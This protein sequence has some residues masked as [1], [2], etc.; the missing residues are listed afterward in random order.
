MAD[1]LSQSGFDK[2]IESL[3][4]DLVKAQKS[5]NEKVGESV[6]TSSV[7]LENMMEQTTKSL[8]LATQRSTEMIQQTLISQFMMSR[9]LRA[10]S[11]EE[12]SD[13]LTGLLGVATAAANSAKSFQQDEEA[14]EKKSIFL[15]TNMKNALGALVNLSSVNKLSETERRREEK[16]ASDAMLGAITELGGAFETF[17]GKLK[18][19]LGLATNPLALIGAILGV[20]AG[21][22]AGLFLRAKQLSGLLKLGKLLTKMFAPLKALFGPTTKL[23]KAVR[24]VANLF[25]P[26]TSFFKVI[27]DLIQAFVK[28]SGTFSKIFKFMKPFIKFGSSL[29]GKFFIPITVIISIFKGIFGFIDELK[30]GGDV[31]D[32]SLRAI[33]D[34]LDFLSFGLIDAD[35]L[36]EFLGK[37]LREFI[38]GI[39][40]L[41]TEGFS[42]KTLKKLA[43]SLIKIF[44]S[45]Q[46]IVLKSLGK[47]V[48]FILDKLGF[49]KTAE[50]IRKFFA[51]FNLGE[52][53]ANIFDP[54]I[55]IF[56]FI[57]K[58]IFKVGGFIIKINVAVAKFFFNI[59]KGVAGFI[60]KSITFG[61]KIGQSI[62]DMFMK[63]IKDVTDFVNERFERTFGTG[64]SAEEQKASRA[65]REGLAETA[66]ILVAEQRNNKELS[67][68]QKEINAAKIAALN[69][70]SAA[71]QKELTR[72]RS[73]V[74]KF[75]SPANRASKDEANLQAQQAIQSQ[76]DA[77]STKLQAGGIVTSPL[78]AK[79]AETE[80]EAVV[81]LSKLGELIV[82]PAIA[83]A[84][85]MAE[86]LAINSGLR[87]QR[88]ASTVVAPITNIGSVGGSGGGPS[89]IPL[90]L[91]LRNTDDNLQR[92]M[93]K[94]F[95]G[96]LT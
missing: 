92:M 94:D 15:F 93:M 30:K 96:A 89:I 88:G 44:F 31:L 86:Q 67:Q 53:M 39:K 70:E 40:E 64:E 32:A 21:A 75:L 11:A 60:L 76:I 12:A 38:E 61:V 81:P 35:A 90:P 80:A 25:K 26:F 2:T 28:S 42:L 1:E 58:A 91:S 48:A 37:P 27:G 14:T 41:F 50:V 45:I 46:T 43:E 17:K 55:D 68:I 62:V 69:K 34:I 77:L 36:K 9:Q 65:R 85:M 18:N 66:A 51:K 33:G 95:R 3:K 5:T 73:F 72:P 59:F 13:T 29:L 87:N 74:E 6:G 56:A 84:L 10:Q 24:F 47:L 54:L 71:L 82:N 83:S 23:G 52:M 78:F 22:V 16:R 20:A 79:V 63:I 4:N 7:L 49:E 8:M 57:G 19:I